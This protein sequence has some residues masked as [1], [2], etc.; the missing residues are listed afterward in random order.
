MGRVIFTTATAAEI[1]AD[2]RTLGLDEIDHA[3]PAISAP[4]PSTLQ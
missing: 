3:L 2:P 4:V 1:L